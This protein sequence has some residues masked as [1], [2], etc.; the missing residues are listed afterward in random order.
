MR[1]GWSGLGA[2]A[3]EVT[4]A[5]RGRR[6][7]RGRGGAFLEASPPAGRQGPHQRELRALEGPLGSVRG[8]GR[9]R[10][11]V[12]PAAAAAQ[13]S[14]AGSAPGEREVSGA[15]EAAT[16]SP[17]AARPACSRGR[18]KGRA[19]V[20]LA[21]EAGQALGAE[22]RAVRPRP[23]HSSYSSCSYLAPATLEAAPG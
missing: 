15:R 8:L 21:R 2:Q 16:S 17:S 4:W 23:N 5:G 14:P 3:R 7:G 6:P 19:R 9:G 22:P 20:Q 12:P 11:G 1:G 18:R 13:G 10:P